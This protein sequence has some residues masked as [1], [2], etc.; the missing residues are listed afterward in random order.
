M[1]AFNRRYLCLLALYLLMLGVIS[2]WADLGVSAWV[3]RVAGQLPFGDKL[4]HCLLAGILSFLVNNALQCRVTSFAR[5]RILTGHLIAYLL[6]LIEEV[7]QLWIATRNV[8]IWDVLFSIVGIH[9]F[10]LLAS[11]SMNIKNAQVR[12]KNR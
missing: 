5:V 3:F 2:L 4:A 1:I 10:G 6:V 7:S 11:R 12:C 9:L 8:E